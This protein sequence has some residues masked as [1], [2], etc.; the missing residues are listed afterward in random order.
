MSDGAFSIVIVFSASFPFTYSPHTC[1]TSPTHK[2]TKRGVVG[3]KY[4][5][6]VDVST[7]EEAL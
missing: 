2:H 3:L 7:I 5:N 1:T 6:E 4:E